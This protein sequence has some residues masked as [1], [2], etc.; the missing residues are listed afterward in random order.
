[1]SAKVKAAA[2]INLTLNVFGKKDGYHDIES[3]VV[4]I[5]LRDDVTARK[6]KKR[7]IKLKTAGIGEYDIPA[8]KNNAYKAA[9]LFSETFNTGGVEISIKKRIPLAGGLGGSSADAAAT[10]VAMNKVFKTNADVKPLADKLG[11]DTGYMTIGGF[12]LIS[13]RGE[14]VEPIQSKLELNFVL[15]FAKSGVNTADCYK[16]FD[17]GGYQG[18]LA[19]N[20]KAKE[21][22][23]TGDFQ[24]LCE[25][26]SNALALPASDL[27]D[28]VKNNLAKL[29]ALSPSACGMTGSG[30]TTFAIFETPELCLWAADALRKQ[31]L[32]AECFYGVDK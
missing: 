7:E 16:R 22:L 8:Q 5:N 29:K 19:D 6:I 31:G 26:I 14:K 18:A 25:Q 27:N 23:E 28:E 21:A 24:G 1:M 12:A 11:S 4:P 17:D 32:D 2:K 3:I 13:G 15:V 10:L 20:Q 30:S 9:K